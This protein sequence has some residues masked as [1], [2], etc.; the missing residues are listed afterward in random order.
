MVKK[1]TMG[2]HATLHNMLIKKG[3][4]YVS[5]KGAWDNTK[6]EY[7]IG[8]TVTYKNKKGDI[9]VQKLVKKGKKA[10]RVNLRISRHLTQTRTHGTPDIYEVT[11][12]KMD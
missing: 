1:K 2:H 5:S 6:N 11:Y 4:H 7:P 9:A 3:Y 8:R 10:Q 12:K